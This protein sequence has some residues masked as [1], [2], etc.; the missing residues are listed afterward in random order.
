MVICGSLFRR[1]RL[2]SVEI[3]RNAKL[4][5]SYGRTGLYGVVKPESARKLAGLRRQFSRVV[6]S[7]HVV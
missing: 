7:E 4:H 2:V 5:K 6:R 3:S 1:H